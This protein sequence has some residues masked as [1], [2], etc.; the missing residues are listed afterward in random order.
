MLRMLPPILRFLANSTLFSLPWKQAPQPQPLF[1]PWACP[2]ALPIYSAHRADSHHSR[3]TA[4]L[5][6]VCLSSI[7][8]QLCRR[9]KPVRNGV[10]LRYAIQKA[11]CQ[12]NSGDDVRC[13]NDLKISCWIILV[14]NKH[15]PFLKRSL[16]AAHNSRL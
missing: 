14:Q 4:R 3:F 13:Q 6:L 11:R 2:D 5:S 9:L 1:A 8:M 15:A 7:E 10:V 16:C 12:A